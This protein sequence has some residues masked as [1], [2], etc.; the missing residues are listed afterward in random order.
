ME[1]HFIILGAGISGLSAAWR[2]SARGVKIDV[3]EADPFV[4]GLAGTLR[5]KGCSLDLGPHSFTSDNR[6]ILDAVLSLFEDGLE[7]RRRKVKFY[8]NGS[9]IDYPLKVKSLLF[10]MG[11]KSGTR[12]VLSFLKNKLFCQNAGVDKKE[13]ETVE[14]WAV[15]NFGPYLYET[16]FKPYTEQFWKM[17]CSE[18]SSRAIPKHTRMNFINTLKVL[19]PK[20]AY[21]FS[22]SMAEREALPTYYPRT[23]CAEISEKITEEIRK[24]Q[25]NI[26]LNCRAVGIRELSSGKI[27]VEYQ[28]GNE[29]KT[30]EGDHLISTI[31]LPGFIEM[32]GECVPP[33][34]LRSCAQLDYKALTLLGMT[35]E[36]QNI[37]DYW[38]IHLLDRPYNR[39]A[40]MNNFSSY[41]SPRNR[42]I[43]TA[44]F[45]CSR[46]DD[47][48]NAGKEEIFDMCIGSLEK[49][50][51]ISRNEV[52][53]L[54]LVK[55][56]YAYPIYNK[57]FTAHLNKLKNYSKAYKT[58]SIL[59]RSGEFMYMDM[60]E[61]IKRAFDL[62]DD[63]LLL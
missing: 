19:I 33:D 60:D 40:E 54:I 15:N 8:Y 58:V 42:N 29:Y 35:T 13:D 14:D 32:F 53:D 55:A 50:N 18:L 1:K 7:P 12:T 45:T 4:G 9:Y 21:K 2:L 22:G 31:P 44:E 39:T 34:V 26:K 23:G 63:L 17:T 11:F 25:G 48:W 20:R 27:Q 47:I 51:F 5:T 6:E 46:S 38:Y 28:E 37:L 16:F 43:L 52:E 62:A 10:Q 49:D 24:K 36:K 30:I 3:L 56:P 41:T 61:C 57:D 59:G